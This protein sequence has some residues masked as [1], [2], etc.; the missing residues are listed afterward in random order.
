[1]ATALC[2]DSTEK[3]LTSALKLDKQSAAVIL[4]TSADNSTTKTTLTTLALCYIKIPHV[5]EIP[6]LLKLTDKN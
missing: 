2:I 1:M 5:T 4:F 3:H 6:K